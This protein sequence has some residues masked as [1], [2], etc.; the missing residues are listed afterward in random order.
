M[1]GLMRW[2]MIGYLAAL[3]VAGIITGAAVMARTTAGT[4]TLK[5]GRTEEI[6]ELIRQRFHVLAL[7]TEQRQKFDPLIKK[8]SEELEASHLGCLER[9]SAAVESLEAQIRPDLSP[10][11]LEKLKQLETERRAMLRQKYN[12]PPETQAGKL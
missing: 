2:R 12:Y 7:T 3:F 1:N 11:Q 6:Q 4:Q 8:A 10:D 5:V 9:C